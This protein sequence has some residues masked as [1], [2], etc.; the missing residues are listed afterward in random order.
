M[1]TAMKLSMASRFLF[2]FGIGFGMP[3][4]A[5]QSLGQDSERLANAGFEDEANLSAWKSWVY[6]EGKAPLIHVDDAEFKERR[7][8]LLIQAEEPADVA[9]GQKVKL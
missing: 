7:R 1:E 8:S 3:G 5:G 2:T 6:A 9:L 4:S